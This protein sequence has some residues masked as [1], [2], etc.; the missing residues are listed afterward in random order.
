MIIYFLAHDGQSHGP[1][2]GLIAVLVAGA[3]L[4]ILLLL[5]LL[6]RALRRSPERRS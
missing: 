1:D 5:P 2:L 4:A 3:V 6:I